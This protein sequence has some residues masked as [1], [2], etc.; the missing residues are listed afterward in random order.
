MDPVVFKG[1]R[2]VILP[3][4]VFAIHLHHSWNTLYLLLEI[5]QSI[6]GRKKVGC[7]G[8]I[9]LSYVPEILYLVE[10]EK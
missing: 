7:V 8:Y 2:R 1:D 5:N 6:N 4:S 9:A 3:N 10:E